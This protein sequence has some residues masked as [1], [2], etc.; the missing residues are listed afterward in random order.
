MRADALAALVA[1]AVAVWVV[2]RDIVAYDRPPPA[3]VALPPPA[4][5]YAPPVYAAP[6]EVAVEPDDG[7]ILS[8]LRE[9]EHDERSGLRRAGSAVVLVTVTLLVAGAVG[10]GIY[11][12]V[13][14]L[15]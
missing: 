14:G 3:P 11:R 5:V 10:A 8:G 4:P 1:V 13:S 7:S 15:G 6:V 2:L 12:V 9:V